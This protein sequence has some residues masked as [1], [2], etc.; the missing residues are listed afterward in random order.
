MKNILL[1]ILAF[2]AILLI[3]CDDNA[4]DTWEEYKDWREANNNWLAEQ[5]M[6]KNPDGTPVYE[7]LVAPW[8]PQ[9]Y[10]LIKYLNDRSLTEGNLS[11]IYTSRIDVRYHLELYT[12]KGVDSS[13]LQTEWGKGIYRTNL[14][15]VVDGWVLALG[16]MRVGDT[17]EVLV[18]YSMAYGMSGSGSVLPYSNLRF[19]IRLVDIVNYET[20][21]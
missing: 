1:A 18:P 2:L 8:N 9:G 19:G 14:N 7:K 12:G 4:K 6:L 20:R 13:D 11:P 3:A 17:A 16:Q 10:V 21:P 5:E 15:E